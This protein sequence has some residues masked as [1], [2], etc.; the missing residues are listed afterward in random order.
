MNIINGLSGMIGKTPLY[1]IDRIASKENC[2]ARILVKAE[3]MNPGGSIK[4]RAALYMLNA[5]K[6]E[7]KIGENTVI[8]EPT[9]GNT[10]IGLAML[11][12][13]EGR[14]LILTMP[15][16]MSKERM[17]IFAAYGAELVLTA[18]R[19]GMKGCVEKAKELSE[20]IPDSF[21]P[22]Q[23]E[24][25]ANALAHYETTGPEIWEDCDGRVDIFVSAFGTGGTVSGSARFLKEKNEK[26]KIC[27][28]EPASSPLVTEGKAGGHKIQGIGANF[29]PDV[30]DLSLVDE[31]ITVTNEDA[32]EYCRRLAREEGLLAGISS[33]A[34]VAAAVKL[35][36]MPENRGKVIVT[37]LPDTGMRYISTEG[38]FT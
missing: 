24:N 11:C 2:G 7:G 25:P 4:D 37:V 20:K 14:R 15:D 38:L 10:G 13:A 18:G 26:I 19:D 17:G 31:V 21:I 1:A 33:G 6:K 36:A 22:S 34:A 12:A 23:F 16:S 35:G 5:A 28:V 32:Y 8:I 27:A 3:F 29:I 9:S 30:L